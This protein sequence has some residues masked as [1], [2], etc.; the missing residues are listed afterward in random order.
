MT[1][2]ITMGMPMTQ[3]QDTGGALPPHTVDGANRVPDKTGAL[4]SPTPVT[5]EALQLRSPAV[6]NG[7]QLPKEY[8]GDGKSATLP[9]EW[10]GVPEATR[11]LAVV[12]HHIDREGKTKWYWLLYNLPATIHGLPKNV[13]G[14]GTLG[15]NSINGRTEYAP[16]HS[17]GPGPKIYVYTLYALSAPVK[18]GVKPAK[19]SRDILLGAMRNRILAT[20]ELKA[21]YS[22]PVMS[23]P[24]PANPTT[25]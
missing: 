11:S 18:I 21:V 25:K 8:T 10:S 12:M 14:I 13:K 17:K 2:L 6:A 5:R 15:N 4:A 9:L 7:G 19:V 16:P 23:H 3:G 22:R 24:S 1:L 20:A